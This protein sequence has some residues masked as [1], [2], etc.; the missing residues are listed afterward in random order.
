M[1][2]QECR[3]EDIAIETQPRCFKK[4]KSRNIFKISSNLGLC[5]FERFALVARAA[6]DALRGRHA[7]RAALTT[8][9]RGQK[10]R[11]RGG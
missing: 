3:D 8:A 10:A 11:A 2:D 6:S 7:R 1:A 4:W 5:I 9:T